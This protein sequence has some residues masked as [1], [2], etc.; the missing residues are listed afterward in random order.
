MTVLLLLEVQENMDPSQF[1]RRLGKEDLVK[2]TR[3]KLQ[4][5][6]DCT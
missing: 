2:K 6:D 5:G 1:M 4:V 3:K